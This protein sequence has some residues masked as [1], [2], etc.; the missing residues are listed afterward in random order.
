MDTRDYND[1]PV[2]EDL[3]CRR[4]DDICRPV[5]LSINGTPVNLTGCTLTLYVTGQTPVTITP[6]QPEG[7]LWTLYLPPSMTVGTDQGQLIYSVVLVAPEGH[8]Q[9]PLGATKSLR[10]GTIDLSVTVPR[11]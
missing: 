7:G 6:D 4:G 2:I 8:V 11:D 1:L 5:C 3:K 10:E 9:F